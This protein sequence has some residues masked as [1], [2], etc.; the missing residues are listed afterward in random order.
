LG[1]S[2]F[3]KNC[4]K[5]IGVV[6]RNPADPANCGRTFDEFVHRIPGCAFLK[7]TRIYD[8]LADIYYR[9]ATNYTIRRNFGEY[10]HQREN[11]ILG[12]L[13]KR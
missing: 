2:L 3:S 1:S 12:C 11:Y 5:I 13:K 7:L 6:P 9:V 10:R 4:T 8:W